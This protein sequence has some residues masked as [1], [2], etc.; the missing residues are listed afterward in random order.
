MKWLITGGCGFIGLNLVKDLL[1]AGEHRV[2]I[3]DNTSVGTREDLASICNYTESK[4]SK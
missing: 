2:R 1:K 4:R 3:I